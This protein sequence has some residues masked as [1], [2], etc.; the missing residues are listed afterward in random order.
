[1]RQCCVLALSTVATAVSLIGYADVLPVSAPRVTV[2]HVDAREPLGMFSP[3]DVF[4]AGLDGLKHGEIA[5]VYQPENIREM[6][7]V[8]FRRLSYRLRTE[9]ASEAWH[10]NENGTWSDAD[11][12]QGY[13]TSSVKSDKPLLISHGYRLPRR[14]NT[15][16]QAN[17]DGYS[18]LDDGDLSTFWKSN[19]YL[20]P[21]FAGADGA[22]YPQ[23]VVIDLGTQRDI[24]ALRISW[25][26]PFAVRFEVQYW[27]GQDAEYFNDLV[28]GTWDTFPHGSIENAKGG[29]DLL[30]LS[31]GPVRARYMRVV[32]TQSSSTAPPGSH[33]VRDSLGFAIREIA[34]GILGT[35]GTLDDV[36]L[37]SPS[38]Q[39]TVVYTSSTD[40]WHRRA[41]R[42]GFDRVASSGLTHGLPMLVPTGLLYDTPDN[43]AAEVTFLKARG[44]T[45]THVELGEEPDGQNVMPEHYGMLFAQFAD[46]IH[47]VDLGVATG[48]P[49]L[50]S[51]VD[52][53]D[54]FADESGNRSWINRL[55]S[56][57]RNR[58]HLADLGFF[59]FEWYPVDDLCAPSDAQLARHPDLMTRLIRRLESEGVPRS[60][61]WIISEY[62]YSSFAGE[63]DLE[64]P[65]A[66]M[67]AEIVPQ[68]L[69]LGGSA[70]YFYGLEPRHPVRELK[71]CDTWGNFMMLLARPDGRAE[72]RLPTY[73]AEKLLTNEW[74]QEMDADH[75][76][77]PVYIDADATNHAI[78]AYALRRPDGQWAIL[79]LNKGRDARQVRV[80]IENGASRADLRAPLTVLQYS[81]K[82][83]QWNAEAELGKPLRSE[84]P[85]E[86]QVIAP[87]S[88]VELPPVSLTIVRGPAG[89]GR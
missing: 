89:L 1:M 48:G 14:G 71:E 42:S 24:D 62:G 64:L 67:Y 74:A 70:A 26:D 28:L 27:S 86:R 40:P 69:T 13:W 45:V 7:S 58:G 73:Y 9:L 54:T 85:E 16:D 49:S 39:Q 43:A 78:S 22:R 11:N 21:H 29:D 6:D 20:D 10:W 56:Y 33:D 82:Q 77:Y 46:A 68:F 19:P 8:G 65:A 52:G 53:W 36:I 72:W 83:Y 59:S 4:G 31:E 47:R 18:R 87:T 84:P 81:A 35:G 15:L 3:R 66:L 41:V 63:G 5:P 38:R 79:I 17:K 23:W 88:T 44:I 60:I 61:P 2:L 34:V 37:H 76:L 30:R 57:L 50:Q 75:A 12:R 80:S 55:V 51:E 25:A 32:L